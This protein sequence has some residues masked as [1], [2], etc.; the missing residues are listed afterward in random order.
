MTQAGD[1][2][3]YNTH[4]RIQAQLPFWKLGVPQPPCAPGV[5]VTGGGNQ[6]TIGNQVDAGNSSA[7]VQ[8]TQYFVPFTAP[9]DMQ[10]SSITLNP[11]ATSNTVSV[12][13]FIYSDNNGVPFDFMG[14]TSYVTGVATGT[15]VFLPFSSPVALL[16]HVQYWIGFFS[17][18]PLTLEN[19][20]NPFAQGYTL[21]QT[22][23]NGPQVVVNPAVGKI[24]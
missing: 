5:T 23:T 22:F 24:S 14:Q 2:P 6:A 16:A 12:G 13:G 21:T 10:I 3:R 18:A 8:H 15:N 4:A 20:A 17:G 1:V 7:T 11:Q 19:G 9:A